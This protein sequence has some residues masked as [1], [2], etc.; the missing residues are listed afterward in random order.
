MANFFSGV[1]VPALGPL[2]SRIDRTEFWGSLVSHES[3][4]FKGEICPLV[5]ASGWVQGRWAKQMAVL[6]FIAFGRTNPDKMGGSWR[7]LS[8]GGGELVSRMG[9]KPDSGRRR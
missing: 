1:H 6:K 7:D 2:C 8:E 9:V 3:G 5:A 4:G